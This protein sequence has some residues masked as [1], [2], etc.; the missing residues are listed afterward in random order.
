MRMPGLFS[1]CKAWLGDSDLVYD[2]LHT[3]TAIVSLVVI[4]I[5]LIAAGFPGLVAPH[6]VFDLATLDFSNAFLPP[7][8]LEGGNWHFIF[9]ADDQGRDILSAI[10]YGLRV[11]LFVSITAVGI[12]LLLGVALGLIAGYCGGWIDALIMRI[13]DVQLTF[14]AMLVAVIVDGLVRAAFGQ[15]AHDRFAVWIMIVAIALAGWVQYARTVR[16]STMVEAG[17]DYVASAK[18]LGQ[19]AGFILFRH[20]LPNV[21]APVFVVATIQLAVAIILEATL[22][23]VGLGIPPTEPSLGTLIRVG[24]GYLLSGEWWLA[25]FP[26][27]ALLILVLAVNLLGDFLR[28]ALNPRLK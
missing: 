20:I 2:F 15:A 1:R 22:S 7:A 3:P 12:S 4:V 25:I 6:P 16:G 28:D 13:A 24:N 23:F 11:S 14:P 21:A 19:S 5:Y 10:I 27:L 9:G 17:R 8:W 26:G 18:L